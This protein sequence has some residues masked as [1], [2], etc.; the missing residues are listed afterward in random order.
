MLIEHL[1]NHGGKYASIVGIFPLI[2]LANIAMPKDM[3][4]AT[5][6]EMDETQCKLAWISY[7]SS[8][9]KLDRA[10]HRVKEDDTPRNR[11]DVTKYSIDVDKAL[12]D[13]K[14]YC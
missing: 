4:L 14:K 5:Q 9:Q 6:M 1:K 11:E 10:K 12:A 3:K 13:I 2:F 8:V 7:E